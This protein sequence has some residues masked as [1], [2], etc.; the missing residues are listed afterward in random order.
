MLSEWTKHLRNDPEAKQKFE[1]YVKGSKLLIDRL[2]TMID[3]LDKSLDR[4]EISIEAFKNPNWAYLQAYQNG[5]R[6]ALSV[7]KTMTTIDHIE[8]KNDDPKR[9]RVSL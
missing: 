4:S 3:G 8:E 9:V 1:E 7:L 5:Y 2:Q 6:G